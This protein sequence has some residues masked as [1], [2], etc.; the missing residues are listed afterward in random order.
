MTYYFVSDVHA[1]LA[2]D[3]KPAGSAERFSAWLDAVAPDAEG[4]FLLG[5]IFDF[6]FEYKR[7]VPQG[8]N[9]LLDQFRKLTAR[10]IEIHFLPGNHDMWTLDYLTHRCGL[11]V[12][13]EALHT[14]LCGLRVYLEHGDRQSIGSPGEHL[15]QRLFRS[16]FARRLAR[17]LVPPAAMMHFGTRWSRANRARHTRPHT[18]KTEDEGIVR[19]ARKY[20]QSHPI[21]L[22]VFGH[23]HAPAA[24]PLSGHTTLY[25]LGDWIADP[26]PVYGRLD[27]SGFSLQRA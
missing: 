13:T 19:F 24:C 9:D 6:W 15:M 23:L 25:V 26:H 11:I 1:G 10:G 27:A 20:M 8:F 4:I 17:A 5:D 12:H 3:G 22:F 7:T 2:M 14:T 16:P 18:F 21:D